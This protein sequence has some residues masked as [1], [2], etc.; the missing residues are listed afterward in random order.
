MGWV[1]RKLPNAT[2]RQPI[3]LVMPYSPDGVV[4]Y[5]PS[6][7]RGCAMAL[8]DA[9]ISYSHLKDKPTL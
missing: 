9:F 6:S 3:L 8:Y 5:P 7:A 2:K 1:G 4:V